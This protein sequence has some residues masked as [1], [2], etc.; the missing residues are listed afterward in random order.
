MGSTP[1]VLSLHRKEMHRL[2]IRRKHFEPAVVEIAPTRNERGKADVRLGLL[3]DLG[4]HHEL[5]PNPALIMLKPEL[6]P[7]SYGPD[8]FRTYTE[9]V[10]KADLLL[11][12][13][14][15]SE[16]EHAY[17]IERLM[18]FFSR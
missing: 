1:L 17:I 16:E 7:V 10:V 5:T 3:E 11:K 9:A 4:F 15:I 18:S 8:V 6:E 14:E 2:E 12:E 13:G